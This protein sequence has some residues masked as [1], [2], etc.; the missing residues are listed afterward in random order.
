[1]K[2]AKV[3]SIASGPG[4]FQFLHSTEVLINQSMQLWLVS[5]N[6]LFIALREWGGKVIKKVEK[7]EYWL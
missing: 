1:M 5:R 6:I 2:L 3:R 4:T 7:G